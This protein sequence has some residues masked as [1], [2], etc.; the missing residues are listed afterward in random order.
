[1]IESIDT[2]YVSAVLPLYRKK[3]LH[4]SSVDFFT[5]FF[6]IEGMTGDR[7]NAPVN[8]YNDE[9]NEAETQDDRNVA[10]RQTRREF[11]YIL[12]HMHRSQ[13]DSLITWISLPLI[14]LKQAIEKTMTIV[15]DNGFFGFIFVDRYIL[16]NNRPLQSTWK[17]SI[18]DQFSSYSVLYFKQTQLDAHG[19]HEFRVVGQKSTPKI[20]HEL[21]LERLSNNVWTPYFEYTQF[22]MARYWTK[23][24]MKLF[25]TSDKIKVLDAGCGAGTDTKYILSRFSNSEVLGIDSAPEAEKYIVKFLSN[26]VKTRFKFQ[27][28]DLVEY[29]FPEQTFDLI[30]SSNVLGFINKKDATSIM[31]KMIASLKPGGVI[32]LTLF[33][34]KNRIDGTQSTYTVQ[35]VETIFNKLNI[36]SIQDLYLLETQKTPPEHHQLIIVTV[37]KPY[38]Q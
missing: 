16:L 29:T 7:S 28:I 2:N 21:S 13:V 9:L 25:S 6:R 20:P 5:Y 8:F 27:C 23:C 37:Q 14:T 32:M 26:N 18:L 34:E 3:I 38:N 24:A 17:R 33:G 30:V 10:R 36:N 35:E 1:M 31:E 11:V 4:K 22:I 19:T 12:P 15:A